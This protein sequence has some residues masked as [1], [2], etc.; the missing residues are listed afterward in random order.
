MTLVSAGHL[1]PLAAR[2][3]A[4]RPRCCS[5]DGDPPLG[6]LVRLQLPRARV[7]LPGRQHAA[8]GHRRRGRGARRG[9]SRTGIER[10]RGAARRR[11]AT[12]TTLC[13]AIADGAVRGAPADDD[14]AVLG[15]RLEL[16]PDDAAHHLARVAPRRCPPCG[17]SCVAGSAAGAR[18]ED[19]IYDIIVAVQ[20]ASA[21]AVEHAYAPGSATYEVDGRAART[22]SRSVRDPR[23]R[24]L[25]GATRNASRARNLDDASPDGI[26]GRDPKDEELRDVGGGACAPRRDRLRRGA[27]AAP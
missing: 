17:R 6:R 15:A 19:E 2:A 25:A 27:P 26:G 11:R 4:G 21:N 9:R 22:A 24:P 5:I 13:Q 7:R 12:S 1:P 8:A 14:V 10:L 16:L 3:R 23:P 20:E 18:R